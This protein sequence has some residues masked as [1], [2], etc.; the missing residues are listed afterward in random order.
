MYRDLAWAAGSN[1]LSEEVVA[2]DETGVFVGTDVNVVRTDVSGASINVITEGE[3][4]GASTELPATGA[5][6]L[7]LA[8]AGLL[9]L[10]GVTFVALGIRRLHA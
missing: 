2:N 10:G 9:A 1:I 5:S 4:L 8:I 3:V 7:W 6:T